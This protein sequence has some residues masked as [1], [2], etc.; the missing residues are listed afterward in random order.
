MKI[1]RML[2][3]DRGSRWSPLSTPRIIEPGWYAVLG[4]I[5]LGALIA[6]GMYWG[7]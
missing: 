3:T 7:L 5:A 1:E 2:F 6:L 4:G